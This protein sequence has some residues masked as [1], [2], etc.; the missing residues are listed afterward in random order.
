MALKFQ[1]IA[2]GLYQTGNQQFQIMFNNESGLW[3]LLQLD[4][5]NDYEWCQ[6]YALLRDAKQGA[7]WIV[8]Q[9]VN[10]K[11]RG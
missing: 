4:S 11:L 10:D 3:Q 5:E 2:P 6:S 8:T 7:Q 1:M 9:R